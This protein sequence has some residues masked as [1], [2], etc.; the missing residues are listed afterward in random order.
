MANYKLKGI[1]LKRTNLNEADRILTIFTDK[2]GKIKTI[3]KGIRKQHSHLAGHLEPFCLTNLV[4]AKG[5]NLDIIIEA[6]TIECF[7]DLRNNLKQTNASYYLS[8][9]IDNFTVE[10]ESHPDIFLLLLNV[11]NH[12]N[13]IK[14]DLLL[15]YFELNLLSNVGFLPELYKCLVCRKK[16]HPGI[17]YFDYQGGGLVCSGCS[18]NGQRISDEGVKLLRIM[19]D[20]NLETLKKLKIKPQTILEVTKVIRLYLKHVHDK[21][22][23][24]QRFLD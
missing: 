22:L 21:D 9:V 16:L 15:A 8:E 23:K 20:K 19:R 13:D 2:L 6:E 3:A 5:R 10:H 1:I 14:Q 17:N 24:S 12:T 11:L 4:I 7:Y 18:K